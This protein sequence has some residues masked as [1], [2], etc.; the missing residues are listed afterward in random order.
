[1]FCGKRQKCWILLQVNKDQYLPPRVVTDNGEDR[2]FSTDAEDFFYKR[3]CG[4]L[5]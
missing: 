3:S 5:H 4:K 1:M 2:T